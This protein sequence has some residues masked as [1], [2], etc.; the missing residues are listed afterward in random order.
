MRPPILTFISTCE[1]LRAG[2]ALTVFAVVLRHPGA[3]WGATEFRQFY[4]AV[5]A[6]LP[7]MLAPAVAAYSLVMGVG[8]WR[9]RKWA[10]NFLAATSGVKVAFWLRGFAFYY[11]VSDRQS[12]LTTFELQARAMMAMLDLLM[13]LALVFAPSV[14]EALGEP[15]AGPEKAI[16]WP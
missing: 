13:F 3:R 16:F 2:L 12:R 9:L 10:R 5:C 1:F 11:Y 8:L 15:N 14:N 6:G 4:A 7:P